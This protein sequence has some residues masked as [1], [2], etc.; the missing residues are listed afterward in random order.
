MSE[1]SSGEAEIEQEA[2]D[3]EDLRELHPGLL[4]YKAAQARNLP[5]MAEALAHGAEINW[6][7]DEDENKTPLIQAVMG[8]RCAGGR[9]AAFGNVRSQVHWRWELTAQCVLV[10][11]LSTAGRIYLKCPVPLLGLLDSLRVPAAKWCRCEPKRYPRPG[12]L[13]PRHVPGAHRVSAALVALRGS[14]TL[15][16]DAALT[17]SRGVSWNGLC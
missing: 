12:P 4:I 6:V 1:E 3:L 16:C 5:L 10:H 9:E 7:N 11:P 15:C 17:L 8:V 14:V 2:S 13:A